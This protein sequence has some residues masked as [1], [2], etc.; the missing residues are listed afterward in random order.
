ML[1]ESPT[2][3]E[4]SGA[5]VANE[6][7]LKDRGVSRT[8]AGLIYYEVSRREKHPSARHFVHPFIV[9]GLMIL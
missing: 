9:T 5:I 1:V 4:V 3:A 2:L 8:G 6:E 7:Y